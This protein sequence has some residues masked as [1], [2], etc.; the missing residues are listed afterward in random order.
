M[1]QALL[2]RMFVG[3]WTSTILETE[4]GGAVPFVSA[5]N[6]LRFTPI[7]RAV[8]LI[9]GDVARVDLDCTASGADSLLASPSPYMS[10]FEFRRAMT[11]QVLLFGNAFAAIN[12]TVSGELVELIV[13]STESV[14][15]DVST[16][17]PI[18][19][20]REYGD[21]TADQ[22]F[23]LRAPSTS[24]LWGD[25]PI[26]LCR[27][28]LQL[29]AAQEDMALKSYRNGGNPKI[30][31][32][33]PGK[34]SLEAMQRM[35]TDYVK[36]HAGSVNA[37]R[38]LVLSEG[39]KVDRISSTIDDTGLTAA[40]AYS[41][42]DVA[43][44]YGVPT[45]YLSKEGNKSGYGSMEWLSQMY[46]DSCLQ[47]WF[48]AWGSEI[49][50]KLAT[51]HDVVV[52]DTDS[53]IHRSMAEKMAALRTGVEAGFITRNEARNS[54][55]LEPLPGL[56]EPIVAKNMGTGG[57]TTNLGTDTSENGGTPNDF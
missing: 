31:L 6:A 53:L 16:G 2:Q 37:G 34:L 22:V 42:D 11:M 54:L 32:L 19:K 33:H 17:R 44:I 4:S 9:A 1:F 39:V 55:D 7:Y 49:I 23:H 25:S 41:I 14:V 18:Y 24:G 52:F 28:A 47:Q 10:A 21:L 46:V 48:Q 15:L 27:T 56:D 8:T 20:T 35:E 51:P 40:R 50:A 38:P 13:L 30:A 26:A 12:R 43:R 45:T 36:R 3:P 29:L 57:G 5:S